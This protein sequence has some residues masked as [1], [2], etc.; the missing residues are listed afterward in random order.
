M[1]GINCPPL[2]SGTPS[3]QLVDGYTTAL[4]A[5]CQALFGGVSD[6]YAANAEIEA[7]VL[8][9][10]NYDRALELLR[11]S[12][13]KIGTA[14]SRFG[15]MSALCAM[16]T[17]VDVDFAAQLE[18]LGKAADAISRSCLELDV[19]PGTDAL[20]QEIWDGTSVTSAFAD[21]AEALGAATVWQAQFARQAA[22]SVTKETAAMA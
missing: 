9:T 3:S 12:G 17:R 14:Q 2:K 19:L 10:G 4:A 15:S 20:Q 8:G 5:Y 1:G 6:F 13:L 11:Q 22:Q 21:A 18:M 7:T 16:V